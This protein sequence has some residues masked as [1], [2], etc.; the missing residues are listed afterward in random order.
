METIKEYLIIA[1]SASIMIGLAE[2][3]VGESTRP[4]VKFI[5]GLFLIILLSFPVIRSVAEFTGDLYDKVTVD[6]HTVDEES[7][8]AKGIAAAYKKTLEDSVRDYVCDLTGFD[9]ISVLVECSVNAEDPS[10]IV[11]E[12]ITVRLYRDFDAGSVKKAIEQ[13]YGSSAEVAIVQR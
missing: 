3:L 12:K 9:R 6:Y 7:V 5:S 10:N 13:R 4:F 8:S 2:G 11:T 1:M